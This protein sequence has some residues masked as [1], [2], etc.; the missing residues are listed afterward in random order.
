MVTL[1]SIIINSYSSI[2]FELEFDID[3]NRYVC[4]LNVDKRFL[5]NVHSPFQFAI[6]FII[7]I[8]LVCFFNISN[9]RVLLI[10]KN[11]LLRETGIALEANC[12]RNGSLSGDSMRNINSSRRSSRHSHSYYLKDSN[13]A[14]NILI[15]VSV[16][17]V[18]FNLP[19]VIARVSSNFQ[20]YSF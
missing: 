13:R 7:P 3:E 14:T 10:R 1:V 16:C 5:R 11:D 4:V 17:F 9:I 8:L 12:N 18:G 19:F 15:F 2:L 20:V 6:S